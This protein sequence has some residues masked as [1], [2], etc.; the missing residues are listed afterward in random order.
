V[1]KFFTEEMGRPAL[2]DAVSGL[3]GYVGAVRQ[4][5]AR[6]RAQR[7]KRLCPPASS[8]TPGTWDITDIT[9]SRGR[10]STGSILLQGLR[11]LPDFGSID[12]KSATGNNHFHALQ[13]S[14]QRRFRSG[15]SFS[16]NYM[17]SHAINDGTAGGGEADYIQN[18]SCRT[19]DVAS[20][21]YDV[22]HVLSANSVYE[23]PFGKGRRYLKN[24][25]ATN[26]AFGGWQLSG[27]LSARSGNT[28]NPIGDCEAQ[29]SEQ[30]RLLC[31][32][33]A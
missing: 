9:S 1:K 22:R 16:L 33:L 25:K 4:A 23:L 31:H 29:G 21:D 32:F 26:F 3:H 14:L 15:A 19:C 8:S 7:A 30:L 13:A 12:V 17:W 10:P 6:A 27:I 18:V 2:S 24:G 20:S 11:Q 28:V 5:G